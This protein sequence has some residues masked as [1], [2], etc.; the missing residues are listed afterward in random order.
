MPGSPLI[1]AGLTLGIAIVKAT[2]VANL[3]IKQFWAIPLAGKVVAPPCIMAMPLFLFHRDVESRS[4]T[5]G[6][7]GR[8]ASEG[9]RYRHE[10]VSRMAGR[11]H[12]E[13]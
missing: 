2:D 1:V 4:R 9:N 11:T 5:H 8:I 12:G 3:R 6:A 7:A 13:E 10:D